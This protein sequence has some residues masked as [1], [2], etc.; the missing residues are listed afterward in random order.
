MNS[1]QQ[2][3]LARLATATHLIGIDEAGR[4]C[5]AGPVTAGAC[6]LSRQ[7]FDSP[8]ALE[9]SA[10]INDS[11]QLS[12]TAREAQFAILESLQM[13][14]LIDFAVASGS[15]EEIEELNILGATRLAMRRAVDQLA[16][17]AVDWHLPHPAAA[18][19]LFESATHV[20]L[21]VD[22][23]PLK[24]FPYAHEGVIKGDGQ[25]LSIA[26]A[27]IA[28]KVSRDRVMSRLAKT[29]PDYGFE[30]HKGYGTAAHRA[31]L[32]LHGSTPMHRALFLRKVLS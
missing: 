19:P 9:A 28:A 3:D 32:K 31:A 20:K 12:S 18:D 27:S 2:Y 15:V 4:G 29:F 1:L 13:S 5:L 7:L 24:P 8:A 21:I 23:R 10:F 22:G 25:S 30:Q 26:M 11:K 16:A 14:G 17:R 6:I